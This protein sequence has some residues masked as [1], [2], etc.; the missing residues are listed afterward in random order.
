VYQQ[1]FSFDE[2]GTKGNGEYA[3]YM[4]LFLIVLNVRLR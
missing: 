3:L 2:N 1:H 4:A